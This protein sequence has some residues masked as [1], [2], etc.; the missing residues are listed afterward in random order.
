M[1]NAFVNEIVTS[2]SDIKFEIIES[3]VKEQYLKKQVHNQDP[4]VYTID[5]FIS[6][7]ECD[8]FISESKPHMK[9]A[10]VSSNNDG[11]V[12]KGRSGTNH[13]I[14][15]NKDNITLS[16]GNRIANY[17]GVPLNVAEQY[18]VIHYSVS[19]EYQ[20]HYD[21]WEHDGSEKSRRCMKWGGQRLYTALVYLNDV[22]EGGSTRLDKLKIDIQPKKGRLL[23]FENVH[24]GTNKKHEM[25][26]HAGMPVLK[27]EKWAFN[28]WFRE[29][30]RSEIV[31]DPPKMID[32]YAYVADA[33][34]VGEF[35]YLDDKK[36]RV[37]KSNFISEEELKLLHEVSEKME[38]KETSNKSRKI[39]WLTDEMINKDTH[40]E[41][42][43]MLVNRICKLINIESTHFES[44]NLVK[45]SANSA[46]SPHFDAYDFSMPGSEKNM[47]TRGLEGQ[48]IIT[49]TGSL[50]DNIEYEFPEI[51]Q[52][53]RLSKGDLFLYKNTIG[54]TTRRDIKMKKSITNRENTE[55]IM[56]HI[57][58]REKNK[59][60]ITIPGIVV[61][62][63]KNT[64]E[65]KRSPIQFEPNED[66]N[67]TLINAYSS[68]Q[69]KQKYKSF[70]FCNKV[71]WDSVLNTV[72]KL[73]SVRDP[74]L[75]IVNK[76]AL[77]DVVKFDEFTPAIV[78]N[79]ITKESLQII[80]SFIRDAIKNNEFVLGDRQS[81][82]YK[83]RDETITRFLHYELV[84][85]IRKLT[86]RPV[87]PTY[88]YLACYTKD[89]DLPAHTDQ[90]DC[91]YTVSFVIDKPENA[92]WPIYFDKTKQ[93]R[94]N[95]GRYYDW[96]PDQGDCIPCDCDS[97]G[98]MMFNGT[99][100]IHYRN[101]CEY[102]YY[103]IVLL[104]YR[105]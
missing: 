20:M 36:N 77:T 54:Q 79:V 81:N 63:I 49:I 4:M 64:N 10:L 47:K 44:I 40:Q 45:Y 39:S 101:A 96:N 33:K 58:V 24:K 97:G 105:V 94:P 30:P 92:N 55:V 29:K 60:N 93:N 8:H 65:E 13:W 53:I 95:K 35:D 104:H 90:P 80:Q 82:R 34:I 99:D 38:F 87:K 62:Q 43:R 61:S 22:E 7:D 76:D 75:G 78:N 98:L 1:T 15:H 3:D 52:C 16:V 66:I 18:Q 42:I 100:H 25:S 88:T 6:N 59:N 72:S 19:E 11:Y 71:N 56:F 86:N 37:V 28:L 83:A 14:P 103:N 2:T 91:E 50:S 5:N 41:E 69:K 85:V 89:A 68:V 46:I 73:N 31:Y 84:P 32:P 70:T 26:Q 21:S 102:D 17:I 48:R 23:F 12:S 74:E 9:Q 57:Y 51:S 67:E 27:G